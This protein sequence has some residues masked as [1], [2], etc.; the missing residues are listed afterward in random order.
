MKKGFTLIE[1]MTVIFILGL[2]MTLAVVAV[3]KTI[4][5][6]KE[7]LYQIQISNIEDAAR[8]WGNAHITL[9]P[10]DDGRAISIPLL[11]LKQDG[12]LDKELKNPNNEELFYDNMYIDISYEKGVYNYNVIEDS[13]TNNYSDLSYPAIILKE[14]FNYNTVSTNND[15]YISSI[16]KEIT[17]TTLS[18]T[19]N[20]TNKTSTLSYNENNKTFT[21]VRKEKTN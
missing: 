2:I 20:T 19:N 21:V 17:T 13:G 14:K 10:D 15:V 8:T 6:N 4:K 5:D 12:L 18:A 11:V 3:D 9:L 1:L 7:N 16:S